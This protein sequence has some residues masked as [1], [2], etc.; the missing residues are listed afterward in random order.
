MNLTNILLDNEQRPWLIDF[1]CAHIAPGEFDLAMFIAIN[2]LTSQHITQIV[3]EYMSLVPSYRPNVDLLNYYILYSFYINGLWYFDNI[4]S[5][6]PDNAM[7][8]LGIEQWSA[9]DRFT[10]EYAIAIPTLMS[11]I[12]GRF[13]GRK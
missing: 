4:D 11:I 5:L 13:D 3:A 12:D 7:Y 9:F 6:D 2:N 1:E 10:N 8:A